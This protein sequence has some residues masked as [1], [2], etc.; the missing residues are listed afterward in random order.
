[1]GDQKNLKKQ[2]NPAEKEIL[3][4]IVLVHGAFVDGSGWEA[5]Y[6][7]LKSKG[8]KVAIVQNPTISLEGDVAATIR[9]I[10]EQ[11]EPVILVGHSYGGAVI[12]EAGNDPKVAGLVYIN[13]FALDK[14][15]SVS[16]VTKEPIPGAPV[17][18]QLPPKDG[19]VL[20]DK[21]KF[22]EAFAADVDPDKAKFMAEAQ[23]PWGI[24][25]VTGTISKASWK[26]K[27]SWYLIGTEDRMVPPQA[28]HSMAKRAKA[29]SVEA[30][31][32][33]AIFVSN[34]EAVTSIIEKAAKAVAEEV[35]IK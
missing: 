29:I 28:Q 5:V 33:H 4:T 17:P 8:Y 7:Q 23:V 34:P 25:A 30:A 20:L 2:T 26:N 10:A 32:S 1:M 22:P 21:E 12:T 15:E 27:P 3:P 13:A 14:G 24:D 35:L 18:P 16:A 9:I 11:Q 19:F 6:N 31:G